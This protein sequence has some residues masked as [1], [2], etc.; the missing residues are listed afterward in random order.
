MTPLPAR[1]V[2]Q[3]IGAASLAIA[4]LV[5]LSIGPAGGQEPMIRQQD[6]KAT[7]LYNFAKF[8]EWP[9]GGPDTTAASFPIEIIGRDPFDGRFDQLMIGKMINDQPIEV[10]H[11][12][13]APSP[14]SVRVAFVSL[15]EDKRLEAL[16]ITY[17][18][19]RVLTVSDIADF[20]QR[21]GIIGFVSEP[22]AVRF[23]INQA[24]A[25]RS[26]LQLS[27]RLLLLAR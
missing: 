12:L 4:G 21:G 18:R 5:A 23:R 25:E 10:I 1:G 14:K 7:F 2:W 11:S 6:L 3:R 8:V 15:S 17:R 24:A 20:T 27:S 9:G 26:Q 13:D 19:N 22:G 16:L